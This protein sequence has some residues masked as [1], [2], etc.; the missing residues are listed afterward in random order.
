MAPVSEEER[1][2]VYEETRKAIELSKEGEFVSV[3]VK[4]PLWAMVQGR[5]TYEDPLAGA[6]RFLSVEDT[7]GRITSRAKFYARRRC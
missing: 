7:E 4:Q 5:F 1:E 3:G 6:F 2:S